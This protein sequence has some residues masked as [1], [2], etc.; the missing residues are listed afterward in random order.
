[1]AAFAFSQSCAPLR[2]LLAHCLLA[3]PFAGFSHTTACGSFRPLA[4]FSRTPSQAS[5]TRAHVAAFASPQSSQAP[6]H[7]L[8]THD[9]L[10][11]LSPFRRLLAHRLWQLSPFCSVLVHPFA[12]FS[13]DRLSQ[14]SSFCSLLTHGRFW[15]LSL[16]AAFLHMVAFS[17]TCLFKVFPHKVALGSVRS[18]PARCSAVLL[19][20]VAP[21]RSR[22]AQPSRTQSHFGST[23]SSPPFHTQS[24]SLRQLSLSTVLLHTVTLGSVPSRSSQPFHTQSLL[25]AF[26]FCS[27]P[28][29]GCFSA[30][31]L[32]PPCYSR[33]AQLLVAASLLAHSRFG[34]IR[35]C[36]R[37]AHSC[38]WQLSLSV[39]LVHTVALDSIRLLQ[40]SRTRVLR[41]HSLFSR[42][43]TVFLHTVSCTSLCFRSLSTFT[44]HAF[45]FAV[46]SHTAAFG[47]I[48]SSPA[49][50]T[51][52]LH[53]VACIS[54][55]FS[56]PSHL[57]FTRVYFR[58]PLSYGRFRQHPP[59]A[60]FSHMG[61]SAAFALLPP[62]WQSEPSCTELLVSANAFR[63]LPTCTSHV[64]VLQYSRIRSLSA[65]F[66]HGCFSSIHSSPALFGSLPA[67]SYLC[68]TTDYDGI[69]FHTL[70]MEA[71]L[72]PARNRTT[73]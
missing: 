16:F 65:A 58:S 7:R 36:H 26:A 6:L 32:L 22:S 57:H 59:L 9:R 52:F 69:E 17:S 23:R 38:P 18:S 3:H 24:P 34:S 54:L 37:I 31:A 21:G 29:P 4:V 44:S 19:H 61:T 49:F 8:L 12:G 68:T 45:V 60:V 42:P 35:F 10:W 53:T 5:R 51:V 1:M 41:Q 70:V 47:S 11:Q 72:P 46:F 73:P 62:F 63:S 39:L 56:Q 33:P 20:T 14:F 27:L 28:A 66:A 2:R 71:H 43:F 40:F 50:L 25:A 13:H 67:Y 64:F 15:Q 48:R 55:R 30:F